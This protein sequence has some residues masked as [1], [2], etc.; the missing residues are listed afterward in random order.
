V[1]SS[2]ATWTIFPVRSVWKYIQIHRN[3]LLYAELKRQTAIGVRF[4][5]VHIFKKTDKTNKCMAMYIILTSV[6]S[7]WRWAGTTGRFCAMSR[8]CTF[9]F[10][11]NLNYSGRNQIIGL[12]GYWAQDKD[13][14]II[15]LWTYW[16]DTWLWIFILIVSS[17]LF[18]PAVTS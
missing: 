12:S 10:F 16:A 8:E 13:K 1:E 3:S 2:V 15:F 17:R 9:K 5:E 14:P 7:S 18:L 11:R 6:T 4:N